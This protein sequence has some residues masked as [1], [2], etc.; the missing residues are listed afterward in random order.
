MEATETVVSEQRRTLQAAEAHVAAAEA[1]EAELN[2]RQQASSA[3][4]EEREVWARGLAERL[5]RSRGRLE[6]EQEWH[7]RMAGVE[8]LP[9]LPERSA[10][11]AAR[12][13]DEV[14]WAT[15]E[16]SRAA[17]LAQVD[18]AQAASDGSNSAHRRLLAQVQS[19]SQAA[20]SA[21][22]GE[23]FKR[24]DAALRD[25][26]GG[27]EGSEEADWWLS[28]AMQREL[29]LSLVSQQLHALGTLTGAD[30]LLARQLARLEVRRVRVRLRLG[31]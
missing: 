13:E 14:A 4:G 12:S 22:L 21:E 16:V 7:A 9:R 23:R 18:E 24:E 25:G 28:V 1:L 19:A 3:R 27:K 20:E 17:Q 8:G 26:A 2:L 10:A 6:Q 15:L 31:G 30:G 29:A 11:A 5:Q